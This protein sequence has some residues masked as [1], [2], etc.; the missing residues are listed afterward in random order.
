MGKQLAI[1]SLGDGDIEGTVITI[2]VQSGDTVRIGQTLLEVETDK[3]VLEVP[4]ETGGVVSKILIEK[5]TPV[6]QG[7][8]FIELAELDTPAPQVEPSTPFP[9]PVGPSLASSEQDVTSQAGEQHSVPLA[10]TVVDVNPIAV[11]H[12]TIAAEPNNIIALAGPAARKLAR[13]LGIPIHS[14]PGNGLRGRIDKNDVKHYAK[15]RL[16]QLPAVSAAPT[17]LPDLTAHGVVRREAMS[18][19]E[20]TTSANLQRAWR[21]IP[22]AWLQEDIDITTMDSSRQQLKQQIPGLT[23]TALLCKALAMSLTQFPRFN[24]AVDTVTNELLYRDNI[25]IG[26][27]VDTPRGLV[28]PVLRDAD[29]QPLGQIAA[30]L[31]RLS[32]AARTGKLRADDLKGA[33]FT[34]SNLGGIGTSAVVPIVNWPEVAILGVAASRRQPRCVDDRIEPRLIMPVTLG[35]D[36]RVINGADG[37]RFLQFLKTALEDPWFFLAHL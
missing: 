12:G 37:A 15:Q 34:L 25:H 1:P 2:T 27:A 17:A 20:Q 28:V 14:V 5:G 7:V 36:H 8:P 23:V 32:E 22:H 19:I 16:T 10:D 13:E 18:R 33:S 6:R 26:V 3:V 24:C 30:A 9:A 21:E 29:Q 4:A 11:N 35:F 31:T